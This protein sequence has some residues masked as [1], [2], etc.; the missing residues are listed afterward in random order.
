VDTPVERKEMLI[1]HR[2]IHHLILNLE[3]F[4]HLG[5]LAGEV[6]IA[7]VALV[8]QFLLRPVFAAVSLPGPLT[9]LA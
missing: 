7:A 3:Y 5:F 4:T 6:E 9:P 8:I 2:P 1:H